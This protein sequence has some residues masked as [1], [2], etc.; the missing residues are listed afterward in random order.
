MVKANLLHRHTLGQ[1]PRLINISP[2]RA[3]RVV[4]QQ[5]QGHDVEHGGEFAVVLGHADDVEAFA[6]LDAGVGIGQHVEHATP[7]AHFVHIA[8]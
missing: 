5:L 3:S 2:L 4:R 7:G 8:F 1:I 6:G